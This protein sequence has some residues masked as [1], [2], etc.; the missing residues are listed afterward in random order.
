MFACSLRLSRDEMKT[1]AS[2]WD[3]RSLVPGILGI[4]HRPIYDIIFYGFLF[5]FRIFVFFWF[6]FLRW[7]TIFRSPFFFLFSSRIEYDRMHLIWLLD[8]LDFATLG[9]K[10]GLDCNTVR[11][12]NVIPT[13]MHTPAW[14]SSCIACQQLRSTDHCV[15]K[16]LDKRVSRIVGLQQ[17]GP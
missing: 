6:L 7:R 17:C 16:L 11:V 3:P 4:Y 5:V 8:F 10:I 14:S 1:A 13:V 9:C 12:L 2:L 15:V